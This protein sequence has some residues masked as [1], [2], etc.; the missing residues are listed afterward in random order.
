MWSERRPIAIESAILFGVVDRDHDVGRL[1]RDR[2]ALARH[3]DADVGERERRRVVDPVADHDDVPHLLPVARRANDVEL[4][5]RVS[6]RRRRARC[7]RPERPPRR[8]RPGRRV[9]SATWL[10]ADAVKLACER[11]GAGAEVVAHHD[12][13]SELAVDADEDLGAPCAVAGVMLPSPGLGRR[14]SRC[15]RASRSSRRRR[16]EP[17]TVPMIP[18]PGVLGHAG[19]E[20]ERELSRRCAATRLSARTWVDIWSSDA[21]SRR[22][23]SAARWP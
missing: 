5:P 21:A 20:G 3:R 10:D 18:R 6:A 2:R 23:S 13:G 11:V 16:V 12:H 4:A 22:T 15:S 1:G 8:S 9:T 17:S 19:R 7:R 14:R